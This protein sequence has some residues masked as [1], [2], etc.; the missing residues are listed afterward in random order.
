M[1]ALFADDYFF[2][3]LLIAVVP[4]LVLGLTE[5]SL[6]V[7]G[8]AASMV[9]VFLACGLGIGLAAFSAFFVYS[10]LITA[11]YAF[12]NRMITGARTRRITFRIFI[13]LTLL[14]MILA[15]SVYGAVWFHILGVSYVTFRVIQYTVDIHSGKIKK[16]GLFGFTYFT[17]FF[18]AIASGPIDRRDR[19]MKD[20]EA[21]LSRSEYIA[22]AREGAWRIAKGLLYSFAAA[23]ALNAALQKVNDVKGILGYAGYAYIYTVYLFFNFA[24]YSA[25]AIGTAYLFGIRM[26]E[27]FDMPFLSRDLKEF[28]TRWHMSLSSFFRDFVYNRFVFMTLKHK[29]FKKQRIGSY[30]GYILTMGLMG[31][32]HGFSVNYVVYGLYQGMFMCVNEWL[33][34][35]T[36]FK[37]L[38]NS[39]AGGILCAFVT[40]HIFAFGLLFFSGKL[41]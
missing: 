11:L 21:R 8:L 22:L 9:F 23:P 40:F 15:K 41:I 37:H 29:W 7:Y 25:L 3:I 18:P 32:W 27:N 19:F 35:K 34:G 17:L 39:R 2:Y 6:K 36:A 31:V 38:K 5:K 1:I 24:G 28:W 30:I 10:Y 14:P 4:A 13:I 33:D 16:A 12:L 20:M 26:V